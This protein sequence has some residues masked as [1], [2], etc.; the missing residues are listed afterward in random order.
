M[1]HRTNVKYET[2]KL[3]EE[4]IF[5]FWFDDEFLYTTPKSRSFKQKIDKLDLL[6]L[7]STQGKA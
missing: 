3:L 6:K 7:K 1:D 5:E 4:N 2:T